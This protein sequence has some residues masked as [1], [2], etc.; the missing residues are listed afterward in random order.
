MTQEVSEDD[1]LHH[2][3]SSLEH[4]H[5]LGMRNP[6]QGLAIDGEDL[7][8]QSQSTIPGKEE[9]KDKVMMVVRMARVQDGAI[10][11][12]VYVSHANTHS[13]RRTQQHTHT[14]TH[15][16]LMVLKDLT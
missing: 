11:L 15:T 3:S 8:V 14:H 13:V 2:P 4:G 7:V 9:G 1:K 16:P 12:L 5:G 10:V 6:L